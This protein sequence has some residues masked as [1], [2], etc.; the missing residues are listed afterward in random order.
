MNKKILSTLLAMTMT[1]TMLSA[2]ITIEVTP[3]STETKESEATE[4][5]TEA[6]TEDTTED[7]PVV[8]EEDI[9][10]IEDS[11]E[12][13]FDDPF[14]DEVIVEGSVLNIYCWND[15]FRNR[16]AAHY[17]GYEEVDD[18][19]ATIGDVEVVW[20]VASLEGNS[21]QSNL[22]AALLSQVDASDDNKVDLF[23]VEADYALKYVNTDYTVSLDDLGIEPEDTADQYQYTKDVVTD[24]NG[25]L[26]GVSWQACPGVMICRRDVAKDVFGTEK[27]SELKEYFANWGKF[28]ESAEKLK[29]AGYKV[30]S[31][32]DDTYRVYSNNL[33][34]KWVEEEK[35]NIDENIKAWVDD[36]K[37]LFDSGM[38]GDAQLWSDEWKAGMYSSGDVFAYFGPAWFVDTM[39]AEDEKDSIANAGGYI[40]IE[41]PQPF[42]WGGTWLCAAAGTD[43]PALI[44]D[45]MRQLTCNEDIM[46]TMAVDDNE[47][48]NNRRAMKKITDDKTYSDKVLGGQNA[49]KLYRKNAAKIDYSNISADDKVCNEEFQ[50]AMRG[51]F[52]GELTYDEALGDFYKSVTAKCPWLIY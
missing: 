9:D 41:G 1:A 42:F 38:V 17:P 36:S 15:E 44:A 4:I 47:F 14:E 45:I 50:K 8:I 3:V 26:K 33:T 35:I 20:H 40:A 5:V 10:T 7:A 29:D 25:I 28:K 30:V 39:M 11:M 46:A 18:T 2:C 37:L 43:N 27:A 32:V 48:V 12:A 52:E 22:D 49:L 13:P 19:H 23:L 6:L 24:Y 16:M 21:Y 34:S 51:Y 31:S